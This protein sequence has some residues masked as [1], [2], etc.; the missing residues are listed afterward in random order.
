MQY[1]MIDANSDQY[2]QDMQRLQSLRTQ[3]V[4]WL[5]VLALG[6]VL[7]P[8][9][10]ITGWVRN[11][12]TRLD[13]ELLAVQSALSSASSPNA[14]VIQLTSEITRINQLV[15]TMQT[16]TVSSGVHWPSVISAAVRYDPTAVE[17]TSLTQSGDKIQIAGRATSNDAVVRYQ[18]LL[19]ES[20]AFTDVVVVSMSAAAPP[21]TP[22]PAAEVNTAV[23]PADLP[24]G[25]VEFVIDLV[26]GSVTP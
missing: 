26:V 23:E 10:L 12:V 14:E 18:Q 4:L 24:F 17:I 20:G 9:M 5:V 13:D 1:K 11:D 22:T 6:I 2:K 21:S 3:V 16:V 7:I 15:S 8:L 25:N 19:L